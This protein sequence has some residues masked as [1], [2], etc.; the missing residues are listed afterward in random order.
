MTPDD[1]TFIETQEKVMNAIT[2]SIW[3]CTMA[4]AAAVC[5]ASVAVV[6]HADEAAQTVHYADLNLNTQAGAA[7]LYKRIRNAAEQV[8]GDVDSR[9]LAEAAAAKA[10]VD[11]AI[12]TGVRSV[13]SPKLTNEYNAHAGVTQPINV[14]SVR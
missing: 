10:C 9:Q 1:R 5:F 6:A 11:K 13:N 14:A 8:C 12:F 7:V 4:A 2:R 3:N